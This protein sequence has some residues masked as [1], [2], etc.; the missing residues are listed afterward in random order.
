MF[1]CGKIGVACYFWMALYK[2]AIAYNSMCAKTYC[3]V[4]FVFGDF[5]FRVLQKRIIKRRC[6][7]RSVRVHRLL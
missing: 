4:R 3:L 6:Q 7:E 1:T 5:Q 2:G